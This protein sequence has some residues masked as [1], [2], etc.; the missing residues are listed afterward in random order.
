[1]HRSKSKSKAVQIGHRVYGEFS[2]TIQ[3]TGQESWTN[4]FSD[5]GA[6]YIPAAALLR[7]KKKRKTNVGERM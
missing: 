3:G 1:M 6:I 4:K 7:R 2:C 5:N